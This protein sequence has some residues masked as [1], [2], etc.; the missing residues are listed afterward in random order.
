MFTYILKTWS[1]N[2]NDNRALEVSI[3]KMWEYFCSCPLLATIL[4][5]S[6]EIES[7]LLWDNIQTKWVLHKALKNITVTPNG[8]VNT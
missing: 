4:L 6:I 2:N 8:I 7:V 5:K 1:Y 3:V